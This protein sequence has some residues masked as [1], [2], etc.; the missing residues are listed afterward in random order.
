MPISATGWI[1]VAVGAVAIATLAAVV[2]ALLA[3][4]RQNGRLFLRLEAVEEQL[5]QVRTAASRNGSSAGHVVPLRDAELREPAPDF[6]LP[7]LTGAFFELADLRGHET[8]LVFWDPSSPSCEAMLDDL[9]AWER[10]RPPLA[11]T[12]V[13]V[14]TGAA[15]GLKSLVL[16]DEPSALRQSF[17]VP[18]APSAVLL[19]ADNRVAS[20]ILVGPDAVLALACTDAAV[21]A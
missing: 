12:L 18:D 16:I 4:L 15:L 3:V 8:V 9:K 13:L 19:D 10:A 5:A 2:W 17:G 11:P 20:E 14:S 21:R 6:R 7:D 1:A